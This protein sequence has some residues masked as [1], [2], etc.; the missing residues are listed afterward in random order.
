MTQVIARSLM[1]GADLADDGGT[2]GRDGRKRAAP[3]LDAGHDYGRLRRGGTPQSRLTSLAV[4]M[5]R[6]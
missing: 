2:G 5:V 3:F 4:S 6:I 1:A